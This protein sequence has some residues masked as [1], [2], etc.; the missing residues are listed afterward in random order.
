VTREELKA[1]R[2][3]VYEAWFEE[4]AKL[5]RAQFAARLQ[6]FRAQGHNET[7]A[8]RLA[9]ADG[10]DEEREVTRNVL[11]EAFAKAGY[12]IRW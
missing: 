9:A 3:D 11:G 5:G 8:A 12:Q 1:E 10:P 7:D 2:P 6:A 4:G